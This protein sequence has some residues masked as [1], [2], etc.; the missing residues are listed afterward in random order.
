[1]NCSND[2]FPDNT[3]SPLTPE[4]IEIYLNLGF[5]LFPVYGVSGQSSDSHDEDSPKNSESRLRCT[6][7]KQ[8]CK[9]P[10]KHPMTKHGFR[11]ATGDRERLKKTFQAYPK[12]NMGIA[13]GRASGIVVLDIDPRNGGDATFDKFG[14]TEDDLKDVPMVQRWSPSLGQ[15]SGEV[16]VDSL[17]M[18]M[19][20]ASDC[21]P[22]WASC[23]L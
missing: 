10:G 5:K 13:T 4:A 1:M 14:L 20:P 9:S 12:A 8:N 18:I 3:S 11:D 6:C 17:L 16:K 15:P 19:P 7:G 23:L 2:R 22:P 21:R